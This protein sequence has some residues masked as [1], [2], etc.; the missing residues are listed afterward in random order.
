MVHYVVLL[1]LGACARVIVQSFCTRM[2][3]CICYCHA[4]CYM[5][6]VYTLK[7]GCVEA[8]C[9]VLKICIVWIY[10]WLSFWCVLILLTWHTYGLLQLRNSV[11]YHNYNYSCGYTRSVQLV[12]IHTQSAGSSVSGLLAK[13]AVCKEF[14]SIVLHQSVKNS[15]RQVDLVISTSVSLSISTSG[16]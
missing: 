1:T 5:Y 10:S 7:T 8:S 16:S 6:L 11:Q 2:C 13:L 15:N 9:G 12:Y 3:V 4:S 14:Y